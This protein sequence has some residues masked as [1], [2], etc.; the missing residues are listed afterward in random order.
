MFHWQF[1]VDAPAFVE[2]GSTSTV[3]MDVPGLTDGRY[4]FFITY[5]SEGKYL[6]TNSAYRDLYNYTVE[7]PDTPN[8]IIDTQTE[9]DQ[10][11]IYDLKG[12][13]MTS[14]RKGLYIINGKKVIR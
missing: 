11:V 14:P 13:K 7:V 2:A 1:Q 12:Q 8:S 10:N 6:D 9:N 4:W 5:K 3:N